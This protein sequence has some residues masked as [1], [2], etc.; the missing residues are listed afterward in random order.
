MTHSGVEAFFKES[1]CVEES[2]LSSF[3]KQED[4]E[5]YVVQSLNLMVFWH[6]LEVVQTSLD[7][8]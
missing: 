4:A 8:Q 6:R 7:R 2:M 3:S 1:G 5:T